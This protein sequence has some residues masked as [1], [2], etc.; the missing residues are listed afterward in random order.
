MTHFKK[1]SFCSG[2]NLVTVELVY[3]QYNISD[4]QALFSCFVLILRMASLDTLFCG[5]VSLALYVLSLFLNLCPK[6]KAFV[7][8]KKSVLYF[9]FSFTRIQ[10]SPLLKQFYTLFGDKSLFINFDIFKRYYLCKTLF[11]P[12]P[13]DVELKF[14]Y[15]MCVSFFTELEKMFFS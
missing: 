7:L 14:R 9:S 6:I 13:Q 4:S 5:T 15:P 1:L 2:G 3:M 10:A 12:C 8:T 11:P